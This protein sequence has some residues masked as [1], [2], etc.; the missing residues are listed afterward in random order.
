MTAHYN[1]RKS[2]PCLPSFSWPPPGAPVTRF[3]SMPSS[4]GLAAEAAEGAVEGATPR[5]PLPSPLLTASKPLCHVWAHQIT[6]VQVRARQQGA[7]DCG[8]GGDGGE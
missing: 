7:E 5:L 8:R 4:P 1:P 6:H 3:S 2:A